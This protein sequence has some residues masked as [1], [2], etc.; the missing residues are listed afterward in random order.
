MTDG[1]TDALR[2]LAG[3][4]AR[5]WRRLCA[6]DP[7]IRAGVAGC[8]T[9][10]RMRVVAP[11]RRDRGRLQHPPSAAGLTT[12]VPSLAHPQPFVNSLFI[13]CT[14]SV[15]AWHAARL[16]HPRCTLASDYADER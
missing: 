3:L 15:H 10:R 13:V 16:R 9:A 12:V 8:G 6:S 14:I 4:A 7:L 11:L 2:A 5:S 1:W